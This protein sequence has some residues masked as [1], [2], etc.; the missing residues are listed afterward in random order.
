MTNPNIPGVERLVTCPITDSWIHGSPTKLRADDVGAHG[1]VSP[2]RL[3]MVKG[4]NRCLAALGILWA[5]YREPALLQERLP[6]KHFIT[7]YF[8]S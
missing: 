2:G 4:Y 8:I 3:F 1:L 7:S 5:A 6:P